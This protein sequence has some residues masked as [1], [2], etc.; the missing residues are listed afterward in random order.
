MENTR[1]GRRQ[2]LGTLCGLAGLVSQGCRT[3]VDPVKSRAN[4]YFSR[5]YLETQVSDVAYQKPIPSELEGKEQFLEENFP[6]INLRN[7]SKKDIA[8]LNANSE[9][10]ELYDNYLSINLTKL[11]DQEKKF[12][13]TYKPTES[14]I[15]FIKNFPW[16]N[17]KN[18]SDRDKIFAQ[19]VAEATFGIPND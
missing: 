17:P 16:I 6:Y 13:R 19:N 9:M 1:V 4:R 8:F 18:L 5:A 3:S 11:S 15:E 10:L 12:L 7:P 14:D 2:F